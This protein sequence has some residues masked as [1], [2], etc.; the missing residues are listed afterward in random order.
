[1]ESINLVK[2]LIDDLEGRI[3]ALPSGFLY[4]IDHERE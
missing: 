4:I 2:P 3:M 1:M